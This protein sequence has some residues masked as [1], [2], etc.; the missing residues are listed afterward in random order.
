MYVEPGRCGNVVAQPGFVSKTFRLRANHPIMNRVERQDRVRQ[1]VRLSAQV[2]SPNVAVLGREFFGME[3]E[4]A[5]FRTLADTSIQEC[6]FLFDEWLVLGGY[7][8]ITAVLHD[9]GS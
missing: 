3:S 5:E 8:L 9:H 6:L 1:H 7:P 4:A 2:S